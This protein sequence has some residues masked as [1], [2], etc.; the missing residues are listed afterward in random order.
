MIPA[1]K[2]P[3][4]SRVYD[5]SQPGVRVLPLARRRAK[6]RTG[7]LALI[8]QFQQDIIF[9]NSVP[10]EWMGAGGEREWWF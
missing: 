6:I 8:T 2:V 4:R 10:G 5:T 3:H 9:D 1:C 7:A